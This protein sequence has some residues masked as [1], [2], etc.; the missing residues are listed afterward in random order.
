MFL[1]SGCIPTTFLTTY[2]ADGYRS[3]SHKNMMFLVQTGTFLRFEA[4]HSLAKSS[5]ASD[6]TVFA[7]AQL[8]YYKLCFGLR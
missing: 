6:L 4:G 3:K 8:P 1:S 7:K 2:I 5:S